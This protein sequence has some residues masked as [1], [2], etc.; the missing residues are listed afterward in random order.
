[1]ENRDSLVFVEV[2]GTVAGVP[3][4]DLIVTLY[5]ETATEARIFV[6]DNTFTI[7]ENWLVSISGLFDVVDALDCAMNKLLL[8]NE[9]TG[10]IMNFDDGSG[11]SVGTAEIVEYT[12]GHWRLEYTPNPSSSTL[13]LYATGS[14]LSNLKFLLRRW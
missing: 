9:H 5:K 1:M 11:T 14:D 2:E 10:S 3:T 12:P 8:T 13:V 6:I 7:I 4:S